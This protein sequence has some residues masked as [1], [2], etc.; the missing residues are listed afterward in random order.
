MSSS[1]AEQQNEHSREESGQRFDFDLN[2]DELRDDFDLSRIEAE[3]EQVLSQHVSEMPM[4]ERLDLP[5]DFD[6][7][8]AQQGANEGKAV[9]D[10]KGGSSNILIAV[11]GTVMVGLLSALGYWAW[12]TIVAPSSPA[13]HKF[14][15]ETIQATAP[16]Q[17]HNPG[18]QIRPSQD[19]NKES[20][21]LVA[22]LGGGQSQPMTNTV[23]PQPLAVEEISK[24][25]ND[26]ELQREEFLETQGDSIG[27]HSDSISAREEN[28]LRVLRSDGG[29]V[30]MSA[31]A[32]TSSPIA[33]TEED[34]LYDK[35]LE[36]AGAMDLPPG[37]I[38]IDP[39]VISQTVQNSRVDSLAATVETSRKEVA[40]LK[41]VMAD[42]RGEVSKLGKA[43][44]GSIAQQS[45]QRKLV[46]NLVKT[47]E[48]ISKKQELDVAALK[49]EIN[50]R[51]ADRTP[52]AAKPVVAKS[53]AVVTSPNANP[54]AAQPVAHAPQARP[55]APV[56]VAKPVV[57]P[58]PQQVAS[59]VAPISEGSQAHSLQQCDGRL[60]SSNWRVKG[61]NNSSAYVV[62]VQDGEGLLVKQ[63]V[64]VPGYGAVK[65][66][67]RFNRTVCTT[68]GLIRR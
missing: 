9:D 29:V 59:V 67:D 17:G 40:D 48:G 38:K 45:E 52:V 47:V 30:S 28:G 11:V 15:D 55:V 58:A 35:A 2:N 27:S 13:Q 62:R 66:F 54:V 42:L 22:A 64:E 51:A 16:V 25:G 53:Q 57:L 36:H 12:A 7:Q 26:G 44:D 43:I 20:A 33:P 37:A 56:E 21:D 65:S 4:P 34:A 39:N 61:I 18:Q 3:S 41:T 63:G 5:H 49:K 24:G 68:Q 32:P 31:S 19:L 46:E 1:H 8:L 14:P 60:V 10:A 6:S 23:A 50:E